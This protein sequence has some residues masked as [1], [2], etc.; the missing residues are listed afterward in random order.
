MILALFSTFTQLRKYKQPPPP[1]VTYPC[2]MRPP[3]RWVVERQ[4]YKDADWT[5]RIH[6]WLA[7]PI[8][9]PALLIDPPWTHTPLRRAASLPPSHHQSVCQP[10]RMWG[11][12][13]RAACSK[14]HLKGCLLS[15]RQSQRYWMTL[16]SVVNIICYMQARS[17]LV[18][19]D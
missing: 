3:S 8:Y 5:D 10:W 6:T 13:G 11:G 12:R 17:P 1:N 9:S 18:S 7:T 19:C 4:A 15:H 16:A 14:Q 2:L